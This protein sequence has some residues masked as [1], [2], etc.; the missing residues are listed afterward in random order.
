MIDEEA[1]HSETPVVGW[2][3]Q[4]LFVVMILNPH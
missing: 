3:V 1:R 2:R 4:D